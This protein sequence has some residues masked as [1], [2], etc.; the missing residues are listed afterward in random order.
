MNISEIA[1]YL[2]NNEGLREHVFLRRQA[3][4][5]CVSIR[6]W[7]RGDGEN[8][9]FWCFSGRLTYMRWHAQAEDIGANDWEIIDVQG[10][11]LSVMPA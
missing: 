9:L 6:E 10:N 11:S 5:T 1:Q 3:W 8:P 7:V 2:D 4:P